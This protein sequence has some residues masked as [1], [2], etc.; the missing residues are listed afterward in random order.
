ML[1]FYSVWDDRDSMFGE[2]RPYIIQFYLVNDTVEVREA[3]E[4]NDGRDP[5]PLLLKRQKLPK[6][7]YNVECKFRILKVFD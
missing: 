4:P 3:H 5:F 1:R 2:M 6:D 7:R